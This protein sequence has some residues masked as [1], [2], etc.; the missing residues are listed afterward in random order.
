[1]HHQNGDANDARTK[2]E[3]IRDQYRVLKKRWE[4]LKWKRTKVTANA[5]TALVRC[6]RTGEIP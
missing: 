1:M 4:E 5:Y 2:S 3:H 6:V